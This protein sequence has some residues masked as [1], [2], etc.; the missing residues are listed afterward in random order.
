MKCIKI[1]PILSSGAGVCESSV[2]DLI[3]LRKFPEQLLNFLVFVS[4]FLKLFWTPFGKD[5]RQ[6]GRG[7]RKLVWHGFAMVNFLVFVSSFLEGF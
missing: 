6:N 7:L 3:G 4:S 5:S 2:L 1:G